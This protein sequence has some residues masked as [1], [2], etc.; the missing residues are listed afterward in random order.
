MQLYV[1]GSNS[2][3]QLKQADATP[4]PKPV[5]FKVYLY[6]FSIESLISVNLNIFAIKLVEG[7]Y[8]VSFFFHA[9]FTIF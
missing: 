5:L 2:D 1:W 9:K 4:V 7:V 6:E 8:S 3:G